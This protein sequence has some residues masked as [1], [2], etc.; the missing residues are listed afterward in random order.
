MNFR[1]TN[2][3]SLITVSKALVPGIDRMRTL[4]EC[5]KSPNH[6]YVYFN[7]D[8]LASRRSSLRDGEGAEDTH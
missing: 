2:L 8:R 5:L 3:W 6:V 7:D 1:S 4:K